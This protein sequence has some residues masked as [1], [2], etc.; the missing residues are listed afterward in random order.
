[1]SNSNWH[2]FPVEHKS[3]TW[4]VQ[5]ANEIDADWLRALEASTLPVILMGHRVVAAGGSDS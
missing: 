1:V 4:R 5:R 2:L 3:T